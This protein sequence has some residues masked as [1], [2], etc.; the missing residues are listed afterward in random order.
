VRYIADPQAGPEPAF[1]EP[2]LIVRSSTAPAPR[3]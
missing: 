3:R 2:E 1:V